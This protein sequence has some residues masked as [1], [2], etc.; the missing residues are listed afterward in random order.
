MHCLE[1]ES[2]PWSDDQELCYPSMLNRALPDDIFVLGW[3]AV[4]ADFDARFMA[5]SRTYRYFF[6]KRKMNLEAMREAGKLLEGEHDFRNFCKMDVTNVRNFV[7]KIESCKVDQLNEKSDMCFVEVSGNAFL[8]HQIRCI[9]GKIISDFERFLTSPFEA[10]LFFVG[11]GLE[12]PSIVKELLDVSARPRKPVYLMADELPLILFDST[13]DNLNFRYD[14]QVLQRLQVKLENRLKEHQVRAAL[15]ST[16]L[17]QC[18]S[19]LFGTGAALNPRNCDYDAAC[20]RAWGKSGRYQPL[21]ERKTC[22]SYEERIANLSKNKR[23]AAKKR[24][25]WNL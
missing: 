5:R 19:L 17:N 9:M 3:A 14:E 24:H 22:S 25:G 23:E 20:P 16:V 8:W 21:L 6:S 10:V 11:C 1:N 4:G 15:T 2:K 13:Y 12:Q 7:R 18:Q